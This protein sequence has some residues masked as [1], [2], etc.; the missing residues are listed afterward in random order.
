MPNTPV[1]DADGHVLEFTIDWEGGLE[2]HLLPVAPR[3]VGVETG[4]SRFL[5]EGKIWPQPWGKG[6]GAGSDIGRASVRPGGTDPAERIKDMDQEGIDVAFNY[7]AVV[8]VGVSGLENAELAAALARIYNDWLADYCSHAPDRLKGIAAIP[9][10]DVSRAVAEARRAVEELG[11]AGVSI[12]SNVH[13]TA[14]HDPSFYPFY[15]EIQRLDVPLGIHVGPGHS[16]DPHGRG[17]PLRQLLHDPHLLPPL[18]ADAVGHQPHLR[19]GAG[20]LSQAAGG[21]PRER[22]RVESLSPG[23]DGRG[24]REALPYGSR[25]AGEAQRVPA[26]GALLHLLR[27]RRDHPA[28]GSQ[29]AGRGPPDLRLRLS[30]LGQPVSRFG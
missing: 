13:G 12:P 19:R 21:L 17:R 2:E 6:R 10:Q 5:V 15:E 11:M 25:D 4:G 9:L 1:I 14:L 22:R 18:R 7:G 27:A 30:A 29:P 8:G 16:R 24:L 26:L 28:D 3:I 23:P 20:A